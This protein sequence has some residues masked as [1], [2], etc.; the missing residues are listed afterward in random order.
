MSF[1]KRRNCAL[2]VGFGMALLFSG[3]RG[4]V[5]AGPLPVGSRLSMFVHHGYL[6][7][8]PTLVRVEVVDADD[9][10]VRD[11]WDA[12]AFLSAVG[13][14]VEMSA[15]TVFLRNGVGSGLVTLAGSG[16]VTLRVGAEIDGQMLSAERLLSYLGGFPVTEVGGMLP[17]GTTS[18][19]GVVHVTEEVTVPAEASL[20]IAAGTLILLNGVASG[21]NGTDLVVR[22]AV[23][24]LG[25]EEMPVMFTAADPG[26]A[27]GEIRHDGARPSVY[28][29]VIFTRGCRSPRIGHGNS[30]PLFLSVNSEIDFFRCSMTDLEGKVLYGTGS[31]LVFDRCLGSRARTGPET[32]ST[33]V[34]ATDSWFME[35]F[36]P[37]DND[38]IY[39]GPAPPGEVHQIQRS[40]FGLCSD[41]AVDHLASWVVFE[42]CIIRDAADKGM[43]FG[44]GHST[45]RNCL[46]VNHSIGMSLKGDPSSPGVVILDRS[47]VVA[48]NRGVAVQDKFNVPTAVLEYFISNSIIRA[49][50]APGDSIYTDYDP[51]NIK[52]SW[53]NI[54][55]EWPG[56]GNIVRDPLFVD[57]A[58]SDFRL[59]PGSPCIDAGDPEAMPD[60][61]GSRVDM[62]RFP[63]FLPPGMARLFAARATDSGGIEFRVTGESGSE[64]VIE[65]T[66]DGRTWVE[67]GRLILEEGSK[68]FEDPG[69]PARERAFY[70]ARKA[71]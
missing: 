1:R 39:L 3:D 5:E 29:N 41:D 27:W 43:S 6:P 45:I 61:D 34:T 24:A 35:M 23:N 68:R 59:R 30:G 15:S 26:L 16:D 33:H 63:F 62:G 57:A 18:W 38:C 7:G 71:E 58:S 10:V 53:S 66:A 64:Y 54:G 19:S 9:Q 2:A 44:K 52:V 70:R 12:E 32:Y 46:V 49:T 60:A 8:I 14:D 37:D 28:R 13:E 25:S 69:N 20:E 36:G 67:A 55:E 42:D 17:V 21:E 47:T 22:G 11:V 48:R 56:E 4:W 40:L 31:R 65:R 51:S 50:D